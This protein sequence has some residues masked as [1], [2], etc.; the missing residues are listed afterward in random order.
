M[1]TNAS[2]KL[3]TVVGSFIPYTVWT[4]QKHN[5]AE[6]RIEYGHHSVQVC[7]VE[8]GC[9][10]P[11]RAVTSI[12]SPVKV[13]QY[14]STCSVVKVAWWVSVGFRT[15]NKPTL[16]LAFTSITVHESWDRLRKPPLPVRRPP[17]QWLFV[18]IGVCTPVASHRAQNCSIQFPQTKVPLFSTTC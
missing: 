17:H 4:T 16:T 7:D 18:Q 15:N 10:V 12:G 3:A 2:P 9:R 13:W 14:G 5:E 8:G 1:S 6:C 11:H